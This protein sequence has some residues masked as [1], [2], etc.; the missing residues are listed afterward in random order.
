MSREN[1]RGDIWWLRANFLL[2]PPKG[3]SVHT[4]CHHLTGVRQGYLD[5][6]LRP[7]KAA[8]RTTVNGKPSVWPFVASRS[9]AEREGFTVKSKLSL[10]LVATHDR[11][12]MLNI[13][14]S[15]IEEL[16]YGDIRKPNSDLP[17]ASFIQGHS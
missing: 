16:C 12:N 11:L 6:R 7:N 4:S 8:H 2:V 17:A 1:S 5:L 3:S 14:K 9:G 15:I 13:M 10:R